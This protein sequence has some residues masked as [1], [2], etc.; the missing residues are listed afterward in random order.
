MT[1]RLSTF[2]A[3]RT[4]ISGRWLADRSGTRGN[5][6]ANAAAWPAAVLIVV[7]GVF[8]LAANGAP[9]DD[10]TTVY[11]AVRRFLNGT[12]VYNEVYHHVDPH[13]LYNP[14]ATLLLTPMG[15]ITDHAW[16]RGVFILVNAASI[17]AALAVLTRLFGHRLSSA[18]WP[19][20]V[21]AAFTTESVRNTLTFSNV[22]GV[23]LLVFVGF[24]ALWI[25][26]RNRWLA[27]LL[28]GAAIVV[29][30]MFAPL[31]FLPLV[32]LDWRTAG[33]A[34]AVPV[35]TNLVAWP[36]VPGAD[37]YVTTVM[38]YL[39]ETRDYANASLA[40]FAEYFALPGVLYAPA[41]LVFAAFCAVGTLCL[42]YWRDTDPL[43]WAT[44]TAGLLLTG[45]FFL[46]SLG[47]QYYSMMLFPLLFTVM[48][49]T[50]VMHTA[51]AWIAAFL[52]LAPVD[53]ASTLAPT[54]GRWAN[55]FV[56]TAGWGLLIVVIATTAVAWVVHRRN[57]PPATDVG[58]ET[59]QEQPV[60]EK[61]LDR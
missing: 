13:Y 58:T 8:I 14:G 48:L 27:G 35:A 61:G 24:L 28:L 41:W 16:A 44:T 46:S 52:L 31:L 25:T 59:A 18:L 15:L 12:E 23:L 56:A 22:N 60:P 30:P 2:A 21:A 42:A 4:P 36:L 6:I 11:S 17:I 54:L 55:T 19:I 20:S 39:S 1:T 47:Q 38:P 34:V 43:L 5:R 10:F 51:P 7:H 26:P 57:D 29:K 49:R 45:V 9:T 53:W 50:S 32:R 3:A 33:A 37:A 40:G